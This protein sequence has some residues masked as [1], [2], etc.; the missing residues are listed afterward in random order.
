MSIFANLPGSGCP[1]DGAGGVLL[2]GPG[3]T[4]NQSFSDISGNPSLYANVMR[5]AVTVDGVSGFRISANQTAGQGAGSSQV[6]YDFTAAGT[7]YTFLAY[8]KWPGYETGDITSQFDLLVS[9]VTF[10]R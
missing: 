1:T 8:V 6:E 5:T 3:V 9:T 4:A 7:R 10:D 2:A